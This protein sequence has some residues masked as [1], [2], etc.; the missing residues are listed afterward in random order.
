MYE[1]FRPQVTEYFNPHYPSPCIGRCGLQSHHISRP[2]LVLVRAASGRHRWPAKIADKRGTVA[3]NHAVR[4]SHDCKWLNYT[5][6]KKTVNRCIS[7]WRDIA[8]L[9]SSLLVHYVKIHASN[10]QF[11]VKAMYLSFIVRSDVTVR[12]TAHDHTGFF[13]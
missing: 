6:G 5:K 1:A 11:P 3:A 12:A 13:F 4:W 7:L 8:H 10:A 2:W 9:I